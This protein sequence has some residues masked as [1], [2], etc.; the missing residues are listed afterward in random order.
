LINTI[1]HLATQLLVARAAEAAFRKDLVKFDIW[2]EKEAAVT[3]SSRLQ[4][5]SFETH[6]NKKQ[7]IFPWPTLGC[8]FDSSFSSSI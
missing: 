2:E 6:Y 5:S 7:S 8:N 4:S 1:G 3:F